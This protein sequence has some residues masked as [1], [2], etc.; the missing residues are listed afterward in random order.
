MNG[1]RKDTAGVTLTE[2]LVVLLII[3]ILGTIAV[4]VYLNRI[5]TA[6]VRVAQA[7]VRE[8][9]QAEDMVAAIHG[10]YVPL[11]MLDDVVPPTPADTRADSIDNEATANPYLYKVALPP[12]A[13]LG[14]QLQLS[15]RTT[16]KDVASLYNN[17]QGPF[18]NFNRY[19]KGVEGGALIANAVDSTDQQIQ[20]DFPLDPWGQPYRFYGPLG[21]LGSNATELNF[22]QWDRDAFSDLFQNDYSGDR[23]RDPFDRFAIVSYGPNQVPNRTADLTGEGDDI[24]YLFGFVA[25]ETQYVP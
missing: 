7:E 9:A 6:R 24:I 18:I 14:T 16:D 3:A 4:P 12:D 19:F 11:Q 10:F 23:E 5:E 13:Q 8:L 1:V 17:W 22:Q 15:D 21:I 2:L 20:R 25:S